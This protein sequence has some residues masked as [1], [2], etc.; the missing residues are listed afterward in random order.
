MDKISIL[1]LGLLAFSRA[2]PIGELDCLD[3]VNRAELRVLPGGRELQRPGVR[4]PQARS[5]QRGGRRLRCARVRRLA[6]GDSS[7][8]YFNK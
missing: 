7:N 4:I 8:G 3:T 6:C 2:S 5:P 1:I